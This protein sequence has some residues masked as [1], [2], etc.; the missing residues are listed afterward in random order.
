MV[1]ISA[2]ANAQ[3]VIILEGNDSIVAKVLSIGTSEINYRRWNNLEGPIYSISVSDVFAIRYSNG[4]YDY[5]S[6][7]IDNRQVVSRNEYNSIVLTRLGNTYYCDEMV[8]DK[9]ETLKWLETQDCPYIYDQFRKGLKT[10]NIGWGL[11]GAGF[12]VG[13]LGVALYRTNIYLDEYD[14]Y[15]GYVTP[16]GPVLVAIG[17]I[18]LIASVPTISVGYSKMHKAAHA[19]NT[20]CNSTSHVTPYWSLQISSHMIG[21]AYNF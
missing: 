11:F 3:D 14:N 2:L 21:I 7:N 6:K 8:M 9:R 12:A 17:T 16:E 15:R 4:T 10:S 13:I 5:F 18:A 1:A 19:Y 20:V